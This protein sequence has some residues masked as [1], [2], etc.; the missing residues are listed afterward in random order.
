MGKGPCRGIPVRMMGLERREPR[1]FLE[2]L[3]VRIG[4]LFQRISHDGKGQ[5]AK[6]R[7]SF[8]IG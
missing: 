6:P 8:G 3:L 5:F 2:N 4:L 7:G 1:P